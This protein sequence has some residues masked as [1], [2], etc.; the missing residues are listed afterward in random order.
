M[1]RARGRS[2]A[3]RRAGVGG[4]RGARAAARAQA[5]PAA[6]EEREAEEVARAER[7]FSLASL[8]RLPLIQGAFPLAEGGAPDASKRHQSAPPCCLF[9][10]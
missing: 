7:C 4:L 3:E 1:E 8:K 2:R 6:Q 5:G 10:T 9:K